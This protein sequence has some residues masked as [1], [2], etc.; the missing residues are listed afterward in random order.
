MPYASSS[1]RVLGR[2]RASRRSPRDASRRPRAA[3]AVDARRA[4]AP[5]RRAGAS[6]SRAL[7]REGERARGR[8]RVGERDDRRA[9]RRAAQPASLGADDD[10]EHRLLRGTARRRARDRRGDLLRARDDRRHEEDDQ[11]VDVRVG[12]HGASPPRRSPPSPSR[13]GRSGSRGSPRAAARGASARARLVGELGQL[14]PGGLAGVGAE[15]PE[16][17][18][19]REHGDAAAARQRLAREQRRGVDELLERACAQHAGLAEER[20][21]RGVGAGERGGVRARG[22]R[23]RPPSS[24]PS[25]RGSACGARRGARRARTCAG[26]RTTRGRAARGRSPGSSSHHSSRSFEETSALFPIETNDEK[27]RPRSAAF[28]SSARPSAPLCEEKPIRPA[29]SARGAKV[30]FRPTRRHGDAEAVRADEPRAVRADEREQPLLPLAAL[31]PGLGEAGRDHAERTHAV[32]ER[33]RRRRR[34]RARRAGR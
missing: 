29:G 30:A 4:R 5:S 16:P 27:P 1:A 24:R 10:R 13:A 7:G 18:R 31:A 26:C 21:D 23:R 14:E 22:A 9:G 3:R 19:V 8:L 28:S 2:R 20:V 15:D 25:A 12:E 6:H 11:R 32:P 17:A 34:A 33:R